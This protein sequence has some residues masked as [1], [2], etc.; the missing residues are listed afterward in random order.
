MKI[1]Q[2]N[3][4]LKILI[5]SFLAIALDFIFILKNISS[6]PAWDQGY[7]IANVFKMYNIIENS[8]IN[9]TSKLSNILDVSNTYRGP[10]TYL[11]SSI[12]LKLFGKSYT[13]VFLSNNIF[14]FL[15]ILSMYKICEIYNQK[16]VGIWSII[17]FTFSPFIFIQRTDYLIDLPL[18]AF[19]MLFFTSL[20]YW[21]NC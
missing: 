19:S 4:Y 1:S 3:N 9:L 17:I 8:D 2:S 6:P 18:T 15:C 5:I 13:T 7:H 21:F 14:N 12:F 11:F 20:T 10:L 16:K